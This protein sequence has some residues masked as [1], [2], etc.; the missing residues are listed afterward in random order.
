MQPCTG[1][2]TH[3][4]ID[5]QDPV[6]AERAHVYMHVSVWACAL[7]GLSHL[8][9]RCDPCPH[10]PYVLNTCPR[11][12]RVCECV[13]GVMI[14]PWCSVGLSPADNQVGSDSTLSP[15]YQQPVST[16]MCLCV[17]LFPR[18]LI[19]VWVTVCIQLRKINTRIKHQMTE[20]Y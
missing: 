6:Y 8:E 11:V 10:S 7:T 18:Q 13:K 1:G 5:T 20:I 16:L 3:N 9:Q 4:N 2:D 19:D 12:L 17:C 14:V 15:K